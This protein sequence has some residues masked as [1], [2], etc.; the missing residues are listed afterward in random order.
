[1]LAGG[2][3]L[4]RRRARAGLGA[5]GLLLGPVAPALG[6]VALA[7]QPALLEALLERLGAGRLRGLGGARGGVAL[8]ARTAGRRGRLF[9]GR[10]CLVTAAGFAGA[11]DLLDDVLR[12]LFSQRCSRSGRCRAGARR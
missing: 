10:A 11:R 12:C 2:L 8:A 1:V 4:G 6:R 7:V 5:L 3:R 9:G